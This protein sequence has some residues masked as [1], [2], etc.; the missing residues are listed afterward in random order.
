MSAAPWHWQGWRSTEL[1]SQP[2]LRR[3]RGIAAAD[4]AALLCL[5]SPHTLP[6]ALQGEG[7]TVEG[8]SH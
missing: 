4:V 5:C 1:L 2:V 7:A 6:M 8:Q 3:C